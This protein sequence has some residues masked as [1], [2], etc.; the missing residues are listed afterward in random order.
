[1]VEVQRMCDELTWVEPLAPCPDGQSKSSFILLAAVHLDDG[2]VLLGA[3]GFRLVESRH[4]LPYCLWWNRLREKP[5]V[6]TR[7]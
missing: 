1:M 2:V 6:R 7:S 4:L 3:S 5:N